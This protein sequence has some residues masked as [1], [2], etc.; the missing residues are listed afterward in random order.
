MICCRVLLSCYS[1]LCSVIGCRFVVHHHI[2]LFWVLFSNLPLCRLITMRSCV[3]HLLLGFL[4]LWFALR[5]HHRNLCCCQQAPI[6]VS[7]AL[8]G[9]KGQR[10]GYNGKWNKYKKENITHKNNNVQQHDHFHF[11]FPV[12]SSGRRNS[13]LNS[14]LTP[15]LISYFC[16][17]VSSIVNF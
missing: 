14:W 11:H 1:P 6:C 16:T 7:I 12:D 2:L 5:G 3:S 15:S 10:N 4:I 13:E 17:R 9:E 8:I